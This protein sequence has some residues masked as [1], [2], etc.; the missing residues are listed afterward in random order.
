[1]IPHNIGREHILAVL[2]EIDDAGQARTSSR[3]SKKYCIVYGDRHYPPKY[4]ISLAN[5][6]ANGSV[7]SSSNFGGGSE[8]NVFLRARGF[9]VVPCQCGGLSPVKADHE[10]ILYKQTT[11]ALRHKGERCPECKRA[12]KRMLERM[13][14]VCYSDWRPSW[15]VSI[16]DYRGTRLE[17]PLRNILQALESERQHKDFLKSKIYP[18]CDYYVPQPGFI[19]EFDESQHF[20]HLRKIALDLYPA[21]LEVQFDINRWRRLCETIDAH[22]NTP[23]YR[24]EQRA[25]Y[26]TLRD[27]VPLLHGMKP[28]VRLYAG[29]YVWCSLSPDSE[30]DLK[31]FRALIGQHVTAAKPGFE[32]PK[33]QNARSSGIL[34]IALVFPK[35]KEKYQPTIPSACE[36][37]D[38]SLDL[39]VFPESYVRFDDSQRMSAL[40]HLAREL[41]AWLFVGAALQHAHRNRNP[42]WETMVLF[43]PRGDFNPLYYKHSHAEAVAFE[44]PDWIPEKYLP[45]VD[46][47]GVRV[48]C[49]ICHDSYLGLLQRYLAKQGVQ[50][51]LNPSFE[52]VSHHK[53]A[54][55]HR[56]RAIENR[57]VSL[58]TL[59][60]NVMKK[61]ATHPFGYG[62]DGHELSGYTPRSSTDKK[63]LS[64]CTN[65]GIYI[66]ECPPFDEYQGKMTPGRL[67]RC[68]KSGHHSPPKND[69]RLSL[70]ESQPSIEVAG[71]YVPVESGKPL[72]VGRHKILV[73]LIRGQELFDTAV[74]W[75]ILIE[76]HRH[77]CKPIFWNV[78]ERLPCEPSQLVNVMLGRTVETCAP[79]VISDLTII[80]DV[81]EIANKHKAVNRHCINAGHAWVALDRA[82]GLQSAFKFTSEHLR[83]L[84]R[85]GSFSRSS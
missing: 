63:I 45:Y 42:V 72:H 48:G 68:T 3:Q 64:H 16:E 78:W 23:A 9:D 21:D 73:G 33:I 32:P 81:T 74:F 56:L 27:L 24:D 19:V 5:L 31:Y 40:G 37:G 7:L 1:M 49:T 14:G 26:D 83:G 28:T 57:F 80:Y 69:V 75:R 55:V 10:V 65:P 43:S 2:R 66:V 53:W 35:L 41:G 50:L 61:R 11:V 38:D 58:C 46:I 13:F 67:P 29:D 52:N 36:F 59:H 8:S 79:V 60:D 76:A 30:R 4:V 82:W 12:V 18:L 84:Y 20:S 71:G 62:P 47:N 54:A 77:R 44:F 70:W 34:K 85:R 39:I 15:G 17:D 51:W 25:W 6:F 22:D